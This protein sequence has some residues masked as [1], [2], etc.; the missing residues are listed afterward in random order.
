MDIICT[1]LKCECLLNK[2]FILS[3]GDLPGPLQQ[4]LSHR[5]DE[6]GRRGAQDHPRLPRE[7]S[8]GRV[9]IAEE[10][11]GGQRVSLSGRGEEEEQVEPGTKLSVPQTV[12]GD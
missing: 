4:R 5:D 7:A 6:K 12:K 1:T 9:R 11:A 2:L 3:A 10:E 8:G